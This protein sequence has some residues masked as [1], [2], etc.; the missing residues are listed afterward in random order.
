M[1]IEIKCPISFEECSK[2]LNVCRPNI[3]DC[4]NGKQLSCKGYG[5]RYV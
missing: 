1:N 4:C 2:F 5:V 3:Y